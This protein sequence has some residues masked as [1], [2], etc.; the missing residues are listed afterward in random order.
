MVSFKILKSARLPKAYESLYLNRTKIKRGTLF[1]IFFLENNHLITGSQK[2]GEK[3]LQG[4]QS[5]VFSGPANPIEGF[6]FL[7]L[8]LITCLSDRALVGN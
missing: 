6:C 2:T 3:S 8:S 1:L 7:L 5:N 4:Y